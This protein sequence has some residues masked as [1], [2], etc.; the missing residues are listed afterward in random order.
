M[1]TFT[2][3][4]NASTADEIWFVEHPPVYT[5]GITGRREHLH[6]VDSIP[7]VQTDR[8]GQVTFHGPGQVVA[9]LLIDLARRKM[10]VGEMVDTMEQ[11]T[12]GLLQDY[13]IGGK[14]RQGAP[15]VY[16]GDAKVASLGLKIRRGR[17]YHGLAVNVAMD[18]SP[19]LAIDPCG[20][21]GLAMTQ[22]SHH[23][24]N[25]SPGDV[26]SRL[27]SRFKNLLA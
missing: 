23:C 20:Y 8:G 9:Y 19:F 15:G 27:A 1:R 25:A 13:R 16:I 21:P 24:P 6:S 4:R 5:L 7:V 2:D 11:A 26:V 22:I 3:Q 18:L 10:K 14:L 17:C 12:L